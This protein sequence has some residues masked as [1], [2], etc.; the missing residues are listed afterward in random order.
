MSTINIQDSGYI[1]PTNEGTQASA[2]NMA[3][4]GSVVTLNSADFTPNLT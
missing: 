3:N 4:S 2:A 1:K